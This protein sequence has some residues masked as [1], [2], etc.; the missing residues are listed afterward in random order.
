MGSYAVAELWVY[1]VKG[2]QGVQV[3]S[4][5]VT[6]A[7]LALDRAFA[8]VDAQGLRYPQHECI[9]AR[10]MP[11][12]LQI[13]TTLGEGSLTL[14]APGMPTVRVPLGKLQ[15]EGSKELMV[16]CADSVLIGDSGGWSLGSLEG[17]TAGDA[18]SEW[19][20]EFLNAADKGKQRKPKTRFEL[21]RTFG[22]RKLSEYPPTFPFLENCKD[23]PLFQK[24]ES[25]YHDF[26][27]FLVVNRASLKDAEARMNQGNYPMRCF[28][29]NIVIESSDGQPW[30]EE[31]W[32]QFQ[33]GPLS[34]NGIKP[35][36]RCVMTLRDPITSKWVYPDNKLCLHKT[37]RQAF[38]QKPADEEWASWRGVSFGLFAGFSV[39]PS[40]DAELKVGD[41][42]TINTVKA[43][44][45]VEDVA[46][47]KGVEVPYTKPQPLVN[48]SS[49]SSPVSHS[50]PSA[51]LNHVQRWLS[52]RWQ[53]LAMVV[54][55]L[56]FI[57]RKMR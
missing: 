4:A 47:A 11:A 5:S 27:P 6:P 2:C 56:L 13:R 1:P 57:R 50:T 30:E 15:E 38:P 43:G 35:C 22:T 41:R 9:S 42:V 10:K 16:A 17:T 19:L 24:S 32:A 33:I 18:L 23:D 12:L 31:S 51:T 54:L 20:S 37:L 29:G 39:E 14:D 26:G 46:P 45:S 21:V 28:R 3:D 55:V 44:I 40:P 7:G 34:L 25:R 53:K 52:A 36:P 48:A 8:V 49:S